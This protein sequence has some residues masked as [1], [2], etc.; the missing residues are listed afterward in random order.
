MN[1]IYA[2]IV[3][4][5]PGMNDVALLLCTFMFTIFSQALLFPSTII[6]KL[7]FHVVSHG[8]NSTVTETK[9][10]VGTVLRSLSDLRSLQQGESNGPTVNMWISVSGQSSS[11]WR[12]ILL[13]T[14][15]AAMGWFLGTS[16]TSTS[17]QRLKVL[18]DT[19]IADVDPKHKSVPEKKIESGDYSLTE[20]TLEEEES[21][22]EET[23]RDIKEI[24]DQ[25]VIDSPSIEESEVIKSDH[26]EEHTSQLKGLENTIEEKEFARKIT[27][28]QEEVEVEDI[29]LEDLSELQGYIYDSPANV[30]ICGSSSASIHTLDSAMEIIAGL[31]LHGIPSFIDTDIKTRDDSFHDY[32]DL[33]EYLKNAVCRY[34]IRQG[35]FALAVQH[36]MA[37]TT[38]HQFDILK[39][40]VK[41]NRLDIFKELV[42]LPQT[43]EVP[44]IRAFEYA[45]YHG[46]VE[47][48]E[49]LVSNF[50]H[51]DIDGNFGGTQYTHPL[52]AAAAGGQAQ[53]VTF[54][55]DRDASACTTGKVS[56]IKSFGQS[57]LIAAAAGGYDRIVE[58]L[59]N[60]GSRLQEED[61]QYDPMK[62][63]VKSG[64]LDII[65][66]LFR[67]GAKL[68]LCESFLDEALSLAVREGNLE[69]A[70]Q[71][72][73]SGA[74]PNAKDRFWGTIFQ[75]SCSQGQE[76]IV[77]AFI[78]HGVR[79]DGPKPASMN[80]GGS[81]PLQAAITCQH[82][83]VARILLKYGADV[84]KTYTNSAGRPLRFS[85]RGF[86]DNLVALIK[87]QKKARPPNLTSLCH[88]M[89][90]YT[91]FLESSESYI[92]Q[93]NVAYRNKV[94]EMLKDGEKL[95]LED[96]TYWHDQGGLSKILMNNL[97]GCPD[98]QSWSI[99]ESE[100]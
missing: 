86:D 30:G 9:V 4:H 50:E 77:R 99:H 56:L 52:T 22:L 82:V 23:N 33:T 8:W 79:I 5:S 91:E 43:L 55:L 75:W 15:L 32:A 84:D 36:Y 31:L 63:A 35:I 66:C 65:M 73:R 71:A 47:I 10:R 28:N 98:A 21:K 34:A 16:K 27:E 69:L 72:L 57:P 80:F 18:L 54:L 41:Y 25:D 26:E 70:E 3:R 58:M 45:A 89:I 83:K 96:A 93:Q 1:S 74:N 40:A 6:P 44:I 20:E 48:M 19:A 88:A 60:A 13:G 90:D 64:R 62:V 95:S 78:A 37:Q 92:E 59:L 68:N 97:R 46:N 12:S 39:V 38:A 11:S 67:N 85:E 24:F 42:K 53:A 94:W 51:I 7:Y 87:M 100:N 76:E 29:E 61:Q 81:S 2:R 49:F 17:W 14:L